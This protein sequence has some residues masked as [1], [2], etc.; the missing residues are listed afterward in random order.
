MADERK[1]ASSNAEDA[2][3]MK[4]ASPIGLIVGGGVGLVVLVLVIMGMS[5]DDEAEQQA[6]VEET[7]K[8]ADA[9]QGLTK[10]EQLER[11]EHLKRTQAALIAAAADDAEADQKK[12]A[13][14]QA[15]TQA[16]APAPNPGSK[17]AVGPK[18]KPKPAV[19]S[20]KSLDSL[21]SLGSDITGALK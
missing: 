18:P 5:G 9:K 8:A 15:Q 20:Q 2:L 13:S 16:A 19:N 11:D 10:E 12:K 7:S 4:K 21:D 14:A 17:A 1:V 3:P 6:A